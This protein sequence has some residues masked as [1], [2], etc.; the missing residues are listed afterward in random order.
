MAKTINDV[1]D[2]ATNQV[3]EELDIVPQ[4]LVVVGIANH[5]NTKITMKTRTITLTPP[6]SFL[7]AFGKAV[8]VQK[9]S[10]TLKKKSALF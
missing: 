6:N 2:F 4:E 10:I 7:Q 3:I 5:A 1:I 8:L 9:R